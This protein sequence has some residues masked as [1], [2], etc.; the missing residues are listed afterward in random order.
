MKG[1]ARDPASFIGATKCANTAYYLTRRAAGEGQEQNSLRRDAALEKDFDSG[2]ERGRLPSSRSRDDS[3]GPVPKVSG[4]TLSFVEF[5]LRSEH[6]FDFI[7]GVLQR[8]RPRALL[9]PSNFPEY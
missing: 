3:K 2:R 7:V 9:A 6:V 1:P 4:L 5:S 8:R